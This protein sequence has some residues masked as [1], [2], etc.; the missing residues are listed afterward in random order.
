MNMI[1][2]QGSNI[3]CSAKTE[4]ANTSQLFVV[5]DEEDDMLAV[6]SYV[7]YSGELRL[8]G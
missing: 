2:I 1:C 8:I 5:Y 6:F 7:T 3:S 4:T